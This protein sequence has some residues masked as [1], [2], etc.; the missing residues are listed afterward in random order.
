MSD[1]AFFLIRTVDSTD[2]RGF[3]FAFL[4][5]ITRQTIL[6]S[7]VI[8]RSKAYWVNGLYWSKIACFGELQISTPDG[9]SKLYYENEEHE[10][11]TALLLI[12]NLITYGF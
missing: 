5:K 8:L 3:D 10:E 9:S 7:H 4:S 11:Q 12:A 6:Q 1:K 2:A